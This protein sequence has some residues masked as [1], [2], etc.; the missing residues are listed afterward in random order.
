MTP[1][2]VK[3]ELP[4]G[5]TLETPFLPDPSIKF[6]RINSLS[7]L[8]RFWK[9]NFSI[10]TLF[11][12]ILLVMNQD[13]NRSSPYHFVSDAAQ[14]DAGQATSSMSFNCDHVRA[15]A[16]GLIENCHGGL[17]IADYAGVNR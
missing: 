3:L 11:S 4:S 2:L 5:R 7:H 6:L 15:L 10:G 13:R 8:L 1:R 16:P 17:L 14:E 12:Q 9:S